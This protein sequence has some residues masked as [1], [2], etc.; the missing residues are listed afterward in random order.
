VVVN[1]FGDGTSNRGTFHEAALMAANWKLPIVFVCENNGIGMF[2]PIAEAHPTED[3]ADLAHGYGM[4]GVVVD[5]Q[6]VVAVAEAVGEAVDRARTGKGPSF[7]ECKTLRIC[8]HALG[9]PDFVGACVRTEAEVDELR[10]RDPVKLF[11]ERLLAG[12]VLTPAD[13]ERIDR[14]ASA[15]VEAAERFADESPLPD[16]ATMK[17]AL[18]APGGVR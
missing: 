11:R 12:G 2:V 8:P 4:P 17:Q 14:E 3:I 18:Y 9:I 10:K 16:P 5:G 1:C 15:E 7:V 6:D 13:V